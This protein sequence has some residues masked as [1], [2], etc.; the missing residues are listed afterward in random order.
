MFQEKSIRRLFRWSLYGKGIFGILEFCGGILLLV[1]SHEQ[2]NSFI[3]ALVTFIEEDVTLH[4]GDIVVRLLLKI[5]AYFSISSAAFIIY[6]MISHGT[7]KIFLVT[8][9]LFDKLWAYPVGL[10]AMSALVSYQVYRLSLTHSL[11]LMGF[12]LYDMLVIYLIWHEYKVKRRL[13]RC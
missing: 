1:A 11:V 5:A 12:T 3:N 9:L 13:A 7:V 4:A 10:V 6:Y 2:L 8:S